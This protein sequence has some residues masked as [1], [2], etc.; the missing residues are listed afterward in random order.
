M[1]RAVVTEDYYSTLE[2][3]Q[4]ATLE[5]IRESYKKLALRFHPDKNRDETATSDFQRLARAWETLKDPAKRAEYDKNYVRTA[6]RR[7]AEEVSEAVARAKRRREDLDRQARAQW[8]REPTEQ[9]SAN[10]DKQRNPH[11]ERRRE[12]ARAWKALASE[13]YKS[14]LQ[15]WIDFRNRHMILIFNCR[16]VMRKHKSD[17]EEQSREDDLQ[18][19]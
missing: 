14:R 4:F 11:E 2:V 8:G 18:V 13:D 12:K 9:S 10:G 17:L 19:I 3:S 5:T 16:R 1:A 6:K 7:N 15:A